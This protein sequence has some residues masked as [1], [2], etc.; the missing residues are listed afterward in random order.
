M[1]TFEELKEKYTDQPRRMDGYLRKLT[2]TET[3]DSLPFPFIK[4]TIATLVFFGG[5]YWATIHFQLSLSIMAVVALAIYMGIAIQIIRSA[6]ITE[7]NSRLIQAA[8]LLLGRVV[9]GDNQLYQQGADAGRASVVFSFDEAHRDDDRYLRDVAK[10]L[11][12]AAEASDTPAD[13]VEAVAIVQNTAGRAV[14][15][16][17]DTAGDGQTWLGVVDVNPERLPENKIVNQNL[18]LLAAPESNLIAQL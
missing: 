1:Y 17:S 14:Q 18:L 15:L 11:R 6:S 8:P 10:K 4:L 2:Y 12:S 5:T 13:L 16:P 7:R 3:G 9:K